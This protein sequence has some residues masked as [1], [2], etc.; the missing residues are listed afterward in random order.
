MRQIYL[1]LFQRKLIAAGCS[2]IDY[3]SFKRTLKRV[4][5]FAAILEDV[6]VSSKFP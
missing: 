6:F 3:A 1:K 2:F 4:R 5:I